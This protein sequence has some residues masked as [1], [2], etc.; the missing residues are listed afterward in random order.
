MDSFFR[1]LDASS[2]TILGDFYIHLLDHNAEHFAMVFRQMA[3]VKSGAALVHCQQGKDRTGIISALVLMLGGV[4]DD[5]IIAN[6][7]VSYSYLKPSLESKIERYPDNM[8]QI[9]RSDHWNMEK[10]LDHFYRHHHSARSYLEN[11]GCSPGELDTI[12]ERLI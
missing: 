12:T 7:E 6:Y 4:R 1:S 11:A 9:L 10:M 5:D 2:D 8:R 3:T